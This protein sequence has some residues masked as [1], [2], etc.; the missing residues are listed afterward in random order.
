MVYTEKTE[1]AHG[2]HE[3]VFIHYF[4]TSDHAAAH[5][6]NTLKKA[7]ALP[8]KHHEKWSENACTKMTAYQVSSLASVIHNRYRQTLSLLCLS[9]EE[10]PLAIRSHGTL[11]GKT[12]SM[13]LFHSRFHDVLMVFTQ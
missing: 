12:R 1:N 6:E 7:A 11:K 5:R 8:Y 4:S 3:K 2:T 13:F 9:E 10:Y